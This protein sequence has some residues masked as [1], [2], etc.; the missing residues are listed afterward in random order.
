MVAEVKGVISLGGG[1]WEKRFLAD[2]SANVTVIPN[3]LIRH[4]REMGLNDADFIFL[5]QVFAL[6]RNGCPV[7]EQ[8]ADLL[9]MEP[10][11]VKKNIASLMEKGIITAESRLEKGNARVTRYFFD[12]L[13]DKL[14][15]LWAC[16]MA[17]EMEKSPDGEGA[18]VPAPQDAAP[19]VRAE[20]RQ[21]FARVYGAF[22]REFGRALSPMEGEQIIQWTEKLAFPAETVLEALKRAVL[23]GILKFN[24]VDRI[25]LDWQQANLRTLVEIQRYEGEKMSRE[26]TVK[27]KP[28][29]ARNSKV[30]TLYEI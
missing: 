3:L 9:E 11:D 21:D 25:L 4:Y 22:E 20:E 2:I 5:V 7:V 30:N 12:G 8:I 15:D 17:V 18:V 23:R 14:M 19:V 28:A 27:R 24:Y 10:A 29:P 13:Y 16:Q 6:T 1:K 26:K